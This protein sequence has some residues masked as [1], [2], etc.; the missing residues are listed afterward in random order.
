MAATTAQRNLAYDA[1][2]AAVLAVIQKRGG[3]FA[4]Q[5]E[6]MI[7]IEDYLSISDAV[8]ASQQP[9]AS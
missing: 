7:E 6:G 8:L 5:I 3:M 4:S 9:K 1:A 2:K